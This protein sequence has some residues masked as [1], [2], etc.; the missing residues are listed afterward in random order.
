V[1]YKNKDDYLSKFKKRLDELVKDHWL[2][3]PEADKQ[4]EIAK[5]NA[6][7]AFR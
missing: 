3:Q 1:L 7:A 5:V 2:L 4:F 6:V